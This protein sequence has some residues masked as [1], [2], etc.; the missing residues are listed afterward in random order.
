MS[1]KMIFYSYCK[2]FS[3]QN[4]NIKKHPSENMNLIETTSDLKSTGL[5]DGKIPQISIIKI[6]IKKV[7]A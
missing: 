3:A 2:V 6:P 5:Q 4:E 1:K 7:A